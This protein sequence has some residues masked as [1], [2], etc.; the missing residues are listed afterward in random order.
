[1]IIQRMGMVHVICNG[2]RKICREFKHME[3][4]IGREEKK[5]T[6]IHSWIYS[7][8]KLFGGI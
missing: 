8:I 1:M 3:N 7:S 5:E 4:F 6:D 2:H